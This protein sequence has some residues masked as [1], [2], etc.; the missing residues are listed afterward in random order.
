ML[1]DMLIFADVCADLSY[2]MT[3]QRETA[4]TKYI[5]M[6]MYG[7]A[8][9]R[10]QNMIASVILTAIL[11]AVVSGAAFYVVAYLKPLAGNKS[12]NISCQPIQEEGGDP[13]GYPINTSIECS[14]KT[15]TPKLSDSE[16]KLSYSD[17]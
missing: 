13:F 2:I 12:K 1:S 8:A 15:G 17:T 4:N 10:L 16:F 3:Q 14:D 11:T 7:V 5:Y 9:V 6:Y